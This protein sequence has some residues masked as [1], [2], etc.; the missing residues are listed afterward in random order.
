MSYI[1]VESLHMIGVIMWITSMLSAPY[2]LKIFADTQKGQSTPDMASFKQWN[3][4][5]GTIG[6]IL[7][8]VT[9][10]FLTSWVGWMHSNWWMV[11]VMFVIALSALHGF[12]SAQYR[13]VQ[14][15]SNY[16]P[17]GIRLATIIQLSIILI[18]VFL[19]MLKP[20]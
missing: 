13:R 16:N 6:I 14:T 15:E 17:R 18:V 9:G 2:L 3:K 7:T 4:G 5:C 1:I 12:Y 11:K 20:F 19:V 10:I 8:W